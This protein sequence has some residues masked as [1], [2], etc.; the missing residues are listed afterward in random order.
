[1]SSPMLFE[2]LKRDI[3]WFMRRDTDWLETGEFWTS[4]SN[5]AYEE[6]AV[7]RVRDW[8]VGKGYV[9][10]VTYPTVASTRL[11]VTKKE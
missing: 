4:I 9:V 11:D 7:M 8:L 1:M 2:R 10:T 3:R 5:T 6:G